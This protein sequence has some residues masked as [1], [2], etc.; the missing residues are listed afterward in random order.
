M[1][2]ILLNGDERELS[3]AI[4]VADLL[5]KNDYAARAVAV[6]INREIVPRSQHA[7]R[8]LSDGDR[9]EI[10]TAFGGG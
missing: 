10:V 1:L 5:A 9:V 7:Q 6:E 2:K 4:S 8:L 3:D